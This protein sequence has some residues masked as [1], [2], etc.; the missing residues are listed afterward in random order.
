M[1]LKNIYYRQDYN[2]SLLQF[3]LSCQQSFVQYSEW[4]PGKTG[5]KAEQRRSD[6]Y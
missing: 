6:F 4:Q 2:W 5:S 3:E 1:K